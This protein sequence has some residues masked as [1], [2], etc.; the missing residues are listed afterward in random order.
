MNTTITCDYLLIKDL[1]Y[2]FYLPFLIGVISFIINTC[3]LIN[4]KQINYGNFF[5]WMITIIISSSSINIII[6]GPKLYEIYVYALSTISII[7]CLTIIS[8]KITQN[9][10]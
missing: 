1:S 8:N 5:I 10:V 3:F 7:S 2:P 4:S 9:N 6:G